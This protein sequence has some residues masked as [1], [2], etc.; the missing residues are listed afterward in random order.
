VEITVALGSGGMKGGAHI[1]VLR[2]LELAGY[3][4]A[5]LAGTSTGGLVGAVYAAGYKPDEILEHFGRVDQSTLFARHPQDGPSFL[6]LGGI[7]HMLLKMLGERTFADLKIPFAVTA[8]DL[9]HGREVILNQG[10]VMDAVLA[11]IAIPGVL[12]P[13]NWQGLQLVDGAVLDPVPASIAR[14]FAPHLPVVAVV[15]TLPPEE[16][17]HTPDYSKLPGPTPVIRQLARWRIGQALQTF[18]ESVD[19]GSRAITEL[20]LKIDKPDVVI[21]PDLGRIGL[22][23]IVD[24]YDL[25]ESGKAATLDCLP[26]LEEAF[27]VSNSL[28]RRFRYSAWSSDVGSVQNA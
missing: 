23:E 26:L 18:L 20:R 8:T 27:T 19:V 4:V 28:R 12:P 13:Q 11:T 5:G 15:L 10:R 25:A 9:L 3:Q 21:R 14:M 7:R 1:G 6:G 2:S 24:V 16:E 17:I 22:T